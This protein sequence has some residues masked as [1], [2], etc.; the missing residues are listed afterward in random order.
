[1]RRSGQ[2]CRDSQHRLERGGK[3]VRGLDEAGHVDS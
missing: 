2:L 1:M 3:I